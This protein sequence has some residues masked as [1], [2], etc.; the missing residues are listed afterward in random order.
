MKK[1]FL[2]HLITVVVLFVGTTNTYA[3][4]K[5]LL[6]T[7][8]G[9]GYSSLLNN[10]PM[11]NDLGMFGANL[12][13]GYEWNWKQF[14]LHTGLEFAS[15]NHTARANDFTLSTPYNIGLPSDMSMVQHFAFTDYT[16]RQYQGVLNIPIMLGG[17][18]QDRYYFLAGVKLGLPVYTKAN[19]EAQVQTY[20]TDPSLVG[21]LTGNIPAHDVMMTTESAQ[22]TLS[23][24]SFSA[25]ASAEVGV[26]ING[27]LKNKKG[28][29]SYGYSAN[30]KLPKY[31]RVGLFCDYGI[32]PSL[33]GENIHTELASIAQPREIALHSVNQMNYAS[34]P[35]LVGVKFAMLFQLNRPKKP[36]QPTSY[37][38]VSVHD[39][40]TQAPMNAQLA[41]VDL[42]TK[43]QTIRQVQKGK[44]RYRTKV[45]NFEVTATAKDYYPL[46]KTYSIETLGDDT[47]LTFA[48]QHRP[49]FKLHVVDAK[50]DQPLVADVAFVNQRTHQTIMNL[51]TDSTNGFL[52][53]ILE[54]TVQYAITVTKQGYENYTADILSISDDMLVRLSP[55]ETGTVIVLKN[56][57]F[58]TFQTSILPESEEELNRLYQ[59]LVENPEMRVRIVGHT[60]NVGSDKDNQILSEG[61]A[62]TV[63][64]AMIER[65]IAPSRLETEGRGEA[66]PID[67]ND[68]EEG[69]ANNR[70][71][72]ILIL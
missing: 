57:Y 43:K 20:L 32:T 21:E 18:F 37:L 65:G 14:M 42:K 41:M 58:A 12:Q 22:H 54:D 62:N 24:A 38:E 35:L 26:C 31:Y 23:G 56:M 6:T 9:M 1:S 49:Y 67:T 28:R 45:G 59:I 17:I 10:A 68:T 47:E 11:V 72:E 8:M 27:F 52:Q 29:S 64:Q 16:E 55:W 63:R 13:I 61:R 19:T 53:K 34:R 30:K 48:L 40:E 69:R 46:T 36:V 71:V 33:G 5:H 4:H 50:T 39:A 15:I 51:P 60:D 70:R 66:Q 7:E 44:L 2:L 25:Q 3:Q